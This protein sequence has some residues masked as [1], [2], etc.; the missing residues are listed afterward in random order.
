MLE[1][2]IWGRRV[3][4]IVDLEGMEYVCIVPG[5]LAY[6][7]CGLVLNLVIVALW[8]YHPVQ[9]VLTMQYG[10]RTVLRNP[11]RPRHHEIHRD[12]VISDPLNR[13]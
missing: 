9:H 12:E 2:D 8:V 6:K 1:I 7:S 5:S 13:L 4:S 11:K 3:M 10:G